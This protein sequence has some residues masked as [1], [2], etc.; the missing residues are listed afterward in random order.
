MVMFLSLDIVAVECDCHPE[1]QKD[2]SLQYY[3][4]HDMYHGVT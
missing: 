1:W 2:F 3:R 4:V